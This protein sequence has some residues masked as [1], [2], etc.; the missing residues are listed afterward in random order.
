[1]P[2]EVLEKAAQ[3]AWDV[4]VKMSRV[5]RITGINVE[6]LINKCLAPLSEK[7]KI[8]PKRCSA[9][10]KEEN[11]LLCGKCKKVWYCGPRCQNSDFLRHREI[12]MIASDN[13]K[14]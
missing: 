8:D 4:T 6:D 13:R 14:K 3:V 5:S 11:L 12:C 1:M 2:K 10:S 7:K 9:C